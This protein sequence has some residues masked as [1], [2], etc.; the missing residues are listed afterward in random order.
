[1]AYEC[2]VTDSGKPEYGIHVFSRH[3]ENLDMD[4]ISLLLSSANQIGLNPLSLD[5]QFI[6]QTSDI[7]AEE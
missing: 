1:M 3:P 7:C 4:I 2:M 5:A 6:D